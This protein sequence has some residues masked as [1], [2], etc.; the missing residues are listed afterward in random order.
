MFLFVGGYVGKGDRKGADLLVEAWNVWKDRPRDVVC[1][2]KVNTT[3]SMSNNW[4]TEL[5][6]DGIIVNPIN[7]ID[8]DMARIYNACDCFVN[9]SQGEGF[10]M[11]LLEGMA[12]GLPVISS[13]F[14][15][16]TDYLISD[17]ERVFP[18]M[19]KTVPAKYSPWDCGWWE[20]PYIGSILKGLKMVYEMKPKKKS[21][22]DIGK[23]TWKEA[24]RKAIKYLDEL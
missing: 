5:G 21:Y 16:Q 23:W 19:T 22:P 3:Y 4:M 20:K 14:G 18:L 13:F 17:N 1:Y 7:Y 10:N 11:A 12:C 8:K 15:G 24:V 6:G 9:P 2:I